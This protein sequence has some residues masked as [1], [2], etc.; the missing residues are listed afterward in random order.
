MTFFE[1]MSA[2][3]FGIGCRLMKKASSVSCGG[4]LR[5]ARSRYFIV[6]NPVEIIRS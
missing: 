3:M 4:E 6:V 2:G 5:L 1:Q